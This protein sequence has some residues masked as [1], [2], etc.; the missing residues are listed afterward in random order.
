M[1][2]TNWL[3]HHGIE[4][5]KWGVRRFQNED[6]TL[7][8]EGRE[9]YTHAN[10]YTL[11]QYKRD[12]D[13]YGSI[14]AKRINKKMLK[15]GTVSGTRT[16]EAERIN[17]TRNAA[18]TVGEIGGI[19]GGILGAFG[20]FALGNVKVSNN[21]MLQQLYSSSVTAGSAAIGHA[22]GKYGGRAL[23]MLGGGYSPRKYRRT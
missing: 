17:S 18:H 10:A 3:S 13:V 19:T 7:T 15:G 14:A 20:G 5:Q 6:G 2:N 8:P 12:K 9:R 11:S 21:L 22:V 4:G 1:N 16:K 23:T